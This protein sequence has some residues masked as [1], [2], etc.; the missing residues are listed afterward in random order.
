MDEP[1]IHI[2]AQITK[3]DDINWANVIGATF[4]EYPLQ[5]YNMAVADCEG[6]SAKLQETVHELSEI[7][8]A[9]DQAAI[10]A[11]TDRKGII[12]Y[13]NDTF[14]KISKYSREELIGKDHRVINSGYHSKEFFQD[15]WNTIRAGKIWKGEIKNKA[16]DGSEYWVST[17]V[18][19]FI[20]ESGKPYQYLAIRFD[21]TERKLIEEALLKSQIK[22]QQQA[23]RLANALQELKHTQAQLVQTEKL[24]TMGQLVAGIAHEINNPVSFIHGNLIHAKEYI[25]D[26]LNLL[27]LYQKYYPEPSPEIQSIIEE[28][29]VDFLIADLPNILDSMQLGANRI[30]DIVISLR[31]FSRTDESGM[32]LVDIHQGIDSTLLILHNRLKGSGGKQP[33][34]VIKEY[35]K[36]PLV[37][38]YAS[39][40]NQVFMNIISNAIDALETQ[41]SPQIISIKTAEISPDSVMISIADN[42]PSIPE[43]LQQNLFEPFFTTKPIGK[44]TGLGLSIAQHIIEE[45]HHGHLKCISEP[46]QGVEFVIAIPI[47]N[48]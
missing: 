30:R 15:F 3:A 34:T 16:K 20:N 2:P 28:M 43:E 42:G 8:F 47:E 22:F 33:I 44:G 36:L 17:T 21:I 40:L 23:D 5:S 10:V 7:K 9:L 48:G 4:C 32:S 14:C 19:P 41:K 26:L 25:R 29:E 27:Y 38:C 18:V 11:M 12:R 31:N 39:Q 46:N 37:K 24:A 45:K 35:G 1:Q 6:M 13:V